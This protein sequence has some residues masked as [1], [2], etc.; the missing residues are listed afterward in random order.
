MKKVLSIILLVLFILLVFS[1]I[2]IKNIFKKT[3][4][5]IE[6][7]VVDVE[8]IKNITGEKIKSIYYSYILT[9]E[10]NIND[11]IIKSKCSGS[12]TLYNK[13][14]IDDIITVYYNPNNI[15]ECNLYQ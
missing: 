13:S 10:Y 6:A 14:K 8:E 12:Q 3:T 1:P 5:P 2:I 15:E 11:K 9:V 7:K 4:I